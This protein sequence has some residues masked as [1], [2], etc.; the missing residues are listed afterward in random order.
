MVRTVVYILSIFLRGL[1][2][3]SVL[4]WTADVLLRITE[5]WDRMEITLLPYFLQT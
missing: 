2:P 4:I 1:L 5:V 3:S